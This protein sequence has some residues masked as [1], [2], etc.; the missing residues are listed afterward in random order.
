MSSCQ[1]RMGPGLNE[2]I[3]SDLVI[4]GEPKAACEVS[5]YPV[6]DGSQLTDQVILQNRG[7]SLQLFFSPNP[8]RTVQPSGPTRPEVA[9]R[10]L[11]AAAQ[12]GEIVQVV[13][14]NGSYYP[15]VLTSVSSP[16]NAQ[17]DGRW[18]T[19]DVEE[20]QVAESETVKVPKKRLKAG[21]RHKA[22][23]V[24]KG[25]RPTVD[26]AAATAGIA[27]LK[28]FVHLPFM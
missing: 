11:M 2:I 27:L 7:I 9:R 26:E 3:E 21:V 10:R 16:R 17:G 15:A 24:D 19:V 12:R 6:E 25:P 4:Q 14:D 18:V 23:P 28:T 22:K 1:V 20:L 5:K 8:D 13:W